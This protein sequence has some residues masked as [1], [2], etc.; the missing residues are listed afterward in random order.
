MCSCH[1]VVQN[2]PITYN[3]FLIRFKLILESVQAYVFY[4]FLVDMAPPFYR[5][6]YFN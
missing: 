5:G 1:D 3:V 2:L 6:K 4:Y